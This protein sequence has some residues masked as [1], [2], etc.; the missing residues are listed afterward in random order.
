MPIGGR[1]NDVTR[2]RNTVNFG[3]GLARGLRYRVSDYFYVGAD[4]GL[5]W[6]SAKTEYRPLD[7]KKTRPALNVMRLTVNSTFIL[8]TGFGINP[9]VTLGGDCTPEVQ[10]GAA[11]GSRLAGAGRPD[12]DVRH[13]QLR[14]EHRGGRPEKRLLRLAVFVEV[15]YH[16]V[17]SRNPERFGTDD[18]NEQDWANIAA[19]LRPR[20]KMKRLAA[21][22]LLAGLASPA[23][24]RRSWRRSRSWETRGSAAK[25]CCIT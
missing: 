14:A 7:Y 3:A 12:P 11:V 1:F 4:Y 10:P 6:L 24:V 17:F 9:Y 5:T 2:L 22:C 25:P 23:W 16:Y 19:E 20:E 21:V 13:E 18:F 15:M 8:S